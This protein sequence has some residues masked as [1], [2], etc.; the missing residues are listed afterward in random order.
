MYVYR[1]IPSSVSMAH[2]G[3]LVAD[4]VRKA[5]PTRAG[6][7]VIGS[8][9]PHV[10]SERWIFST[11]AWGTPLRTN[12]KK[13]LEVQLKGKWVG[14]HTLPG[15]RERYASYPAGAT[16][17]V[18][19]AYS[20][21]LNDLSRRKF[22]NV[23]RAQLPAPWNTDLPQTWVLNDFGQVAIKYF[24]DANHNGKLDAKEYL[25]SDFIHTTPNEEMELAIGRKREPTSPMILSESHGCI[26]MLPNIVQDWIAKGI[27]KVG[28]TI[29]VHKYTEPT[30]LNSF[31]RPTG[32]AGV[33]IH[34]YPGLEGI[35]LYRVTK[36][37]L[38]H[39]LH[40]SH[41]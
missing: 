7:F 39:P 34:F 15:W 1:L 4:N 28:A 2:G 26:H 37:Q 3:P 12:A 29:E 32:R 27:L 16:V 41:G 11:I 22:G 38:N 23:S 25:L 13:E 8:V 40:L 6:R 17:M 33:E 10:S 35:A 5:T 9:G 19:E 14:L 31:E 18:K 30:L 21:L 20:R 36:K 24:V